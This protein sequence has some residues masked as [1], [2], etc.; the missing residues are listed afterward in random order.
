MP[1]PDCVVF[2]LLELLFPEQPAIQA[3]AVPT[4]RTTTENPFQTF[5]SEP[6]CG[7]ALR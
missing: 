2:V 7:E 5:I 1:C 4:V 6:L 3:T